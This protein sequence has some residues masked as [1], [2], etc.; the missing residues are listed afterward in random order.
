MDVSPGF[1]V[2]ARV[3]DPM[4]MGLGSAAE[5]SRRAKIFSEWAAV[6]VDRASLAGFSSRR[7]RV[8][9]RRQS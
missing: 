6:E 8:T 4:A 1:S 9:S 3:L 7:H 5:G 2:E